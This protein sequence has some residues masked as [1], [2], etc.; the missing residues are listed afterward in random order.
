MRYYEVGQIVNTHGIKGE[1]KVAITTDFADERFKK[2]K[3]L[4]IPRDGDKKPVALK[5]KNAR[6]FKQFQLLIFEGMEDIN[7][8]EKY[9]GCKLMVSEQEQKPLAGEAYYHHQIVGLRVITNSGEMLGTIKEIL[10]LGANDVWVVKRSGKKDLLLPAIKD[11]I[12]RVDIE[13]G[14]VN[15]EL[16]DGLDDL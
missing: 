15:V 2:G 4:Y 1:V 12:K 10:T 14:T 13:A 16:L 7:L 3:I 11:V 5:I 6:S 8:I 9:K